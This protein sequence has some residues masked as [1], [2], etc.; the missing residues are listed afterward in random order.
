MDARQIVV[1]DVDLVKTSCGYGVPFMEY[2][3]ERPS[4]DN[5]A[6][7]KGPEGLAAFQEDNNRLSMDGLPTGFFDPA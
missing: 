1:L 6:A 3:A 2:K 4:M 5:W 7:K